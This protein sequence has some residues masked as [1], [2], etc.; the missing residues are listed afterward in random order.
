MDPELKALL[1]K[2]EQGDFEDIP[3]LAEWLKRQND[4]RLER[5]WEAS[6]LEPQEIAD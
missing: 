6:V 1:Q 5:A 2:I 3:K 4:P